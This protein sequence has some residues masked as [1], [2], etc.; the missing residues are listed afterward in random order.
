MAP[1]HVEAA[2]FAWLAHQFLSGLPGN[3]PSVTGARHAVPLGGLY[4][5]SPL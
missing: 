1:E 5:G 4:R 2:G 3:I